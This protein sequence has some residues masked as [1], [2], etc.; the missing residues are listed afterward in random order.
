MKRR[1]ARVPRASIVGKR[2]AEAMVPAGRYGYGQTP[3]HPYTQICQICIQQESR[4]HIFNQVLVLPCW[5]YML[6]QT[7]KYVTFVLSL[8]ISLSFMFSR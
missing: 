1:L 6:L 4:P 2:R 5:V 8:T 7:A 3:L